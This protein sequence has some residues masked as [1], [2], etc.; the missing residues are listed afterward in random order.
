[1]YT[2]VVPAQFSEL[3]FLTT[4]YDI[5]VNEENRWHQDA[6]TQVFPSKMQAGRIYEYDMIIPKIN[7]KV[8]PDD[9]VDF[10][11][12]M[13][14]WKANLNKIEQKRCIPLITPDQ[15]NVNC[16]KCQCSSRYLRR[17]G[18]VFFGTFGE[19]ASNVGINSLRRKSYGYLKTKGTIMADVSFN[20]GVYAHVYLRTSE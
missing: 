15:R 14:E 4:I 5:L 8:I 2:I 13:G 1:M 18:Y 7:L 19:G 10:W 6:F 16:Y 3:S 17:N 9:F 20:S 12:R 11:Q